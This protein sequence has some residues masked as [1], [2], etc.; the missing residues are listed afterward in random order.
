MQLIVKKKTT[1]VAPHTHYVS[2]I[3]K[4]WE[5]NKRMLEI[6]LSFNFIQMLLGFFRIKTHGY[7][8]FSK[9]TKL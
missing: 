7:D 4:P 6:T 5:M 8:F 2:E 3:S 1:I 9:M